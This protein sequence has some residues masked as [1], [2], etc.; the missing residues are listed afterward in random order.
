MEKMIIT[1]PEKNPVLPLRPAPTGRK[2]GS[3][4]TVLTNFYRLT[5]PPT[6]VKIFTYSVAFLP[7]VPADDRYTRYGIMKRVVPQ[8]MKFMPFT[9]FACDQLFSSTMMT[10]T[11][12]IPNVKWQSAIYKLTIRKTTNNIDLSDL[13]SAPDN[14]IEVLRVLTIEIKE[15]M[16]Q[17]GYKQMNRSPVFF[18]KET[19]K[20]FKD[21]FDIYEGFHVPC[22][23][24]ESG[25]AVQIALKTKLICRNTVLDKLYE[26][27]K[28]ARQHYEAKARREIEGRTVRANYGNNR[29]WRIDAI[30]FDMTPG[31]T[32]DWKGHGTIS[33]A[34][35]YS[36]QYKLIVQEMDQPLLMNVDRKDPNRIFYLIPEFLSLT[37][38]SDDEAKRYR[39]DLSM[40]E[41]PG[42]GEQVE[43][44]CRLA[45]DIAS[46]KS[47]LGTSVSSDPMTAE[48]L[49]LDMPEILTASAHEP[50]NEPDRDFLIRSKIL[51]P[52]TFASGSWL[53]IY[54]ELD[55]EAALRILDGI[56]KASTQYG[57][58]I[59]PPKKITYRQ[60]KWCEQIPSILTLGVEE[61]KADFTLVVMAS[62][63]R[64]HEADEC[65][66]LIKRIS[67]K[68]RPTPNQ[69]VKTQTLGKNE[70]SKIA[71]LLL[72]MNAKKGGALW[73]VRMFKMEVTMIMGVD[74]CHKRVNGEG[75]SYVGFCATMN[76][77][78]N[79]FY[80]MAHPIAPGEEM[81]DGLRVCVKGALAHFFEIH[82]ILPKL[83]IMYRDGISENTFPGA[84]ELEVSQIHKSVAELK[85]VHGLA[86]W[87]PQIIY[88][89]VNKR[90]GTRLFE[91]V[92]QGPA[93]G[94]GTV[95][96]IPGTKMLQSA[97]SGTLVT[98]G[99]TSRRYD[100][101]LIAQKITKGI[102][103]PTH[104]HVIYDT[105]TFEPEK[106]YLLTYRLCF[107]YFNWTGGIRIP[108][109]CQYAHKMA[110]MAANYV[111]D[112]PSLDLAPKL[113]YL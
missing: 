67:C 92:I 45:A 4:I 108:A 15:K 61:C 27:E 100:F 53:L 81:V 21:I 64:P 30:K 99:V 105:S 32:F 89:I 9:V 77:T 46:K 58:S 8:L 56:M 13:S 70:M 36:Q 16:R 42:P 63:L 74:I 38:F 107:L 44:A 84:V 26:I 71:K 54:E 88:V 35:Y 11:I 17:L 91:Q 10:Q 79:A 24:L 14:Y 2:I 22:K 62:G 55:E 7:E 50:L 102:A 23:L 5:R 111:C 93:E 1:P 65:Y 87:N 43:K 25:I 95:R 82:G 18:D 33:F 112:A 57:I 49:I 34:E 40:M 75:K 72:Q 37:G 52:Q 94:H 69:V 29:F 60:D 106:L 80:S 6:S 41:R 109:P 98:G 110:S 86:D 66:K 97:R 47:I 51:E 12:E 48:A 101:Y 68:D 76:G 85:S 19:T 59:G 113:F 31:S 83:I 20:N 73:N 3:P 39:R 103:T 104:Y 90:V 78:F 28:S 96:P